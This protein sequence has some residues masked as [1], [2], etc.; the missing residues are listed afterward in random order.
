[1]GEWCSTLDRE[2]SLSGSQRFEV[3][4]HWRMEGRK[5]EEK[6]EERS[7]EWGVVDGGHPVQ[8]VEE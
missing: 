6:E 7:G 5:K 2:Y 1:M 3:G 4:S 8:A